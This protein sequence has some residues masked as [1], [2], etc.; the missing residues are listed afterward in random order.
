MPH[1]PDP[2]QKRTEAPSTRPPEWQ[3]LS[4]AFRCPPPRRSRLL[5][6]LVA[7]ACLPLAWTC[8]VGLLAAQEGPSP[9]D[10]GARDAGPSPE[11][12][13]AAVGVEDGTMAA[14]AGR[15]VPVKPAPWQKTSCDAARDEVT[16]RSACYLELARKPPC[17]PSQHEHGG[18]CWAPVA[19]LPRPD[20]SVR[21]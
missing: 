2:S 11:A 4:E 21:E 17:L 13:E 8:A 14:V 18:K 12:T 15:P 20:S 3:G 9:P 6:W 7:A 16:L 10:A 19:R 1:C 5:P